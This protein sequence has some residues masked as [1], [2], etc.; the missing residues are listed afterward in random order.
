ML[1]GTSGPTGEAIAREL[2]T[3]V[4]ASTPVAGFTWSA[5]LVL[6]TVLDDGEDTASDRVRLAAGPGAALVYHASYAR[7][8]P[9]F[10]GLPEAAR[11]RASVE[12]VTPEYRH[13]E[14]HRGHMTSLN[15]HDELVMTG[16]LAASLTASGTAREWRRRL[17]SA[18]RSGA[19]EV[20]Y[21]PAGPDQRRELRAFMNAAHA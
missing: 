18:E 4:I 15:R 13:L 17:E 14:L 8:R 10:D 19:A 9:A 21:Q 11:W 3:G 16:T 1:I 2:G 7:R 20:V 6:G 12:A 5:W